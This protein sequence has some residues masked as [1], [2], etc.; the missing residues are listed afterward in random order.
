MKLYQYLLIAVCILLSGCIRKSMNQ[1][2][3]WKAV[4]K[5][6]DHRTSEGRKDGLYTGDFITA[7]ICMCDCTYVFADENQLDWNKR[8][9]IKYSWINP[10]A[11]TVMTANRWNDDEQVW[12]IA[13][14]NHGIKKGS[15]DYQQ[16]LNGA[17]FTKTQITVSKEG[18]YTLE[19]DI[20]QHEGLVVTRISNGFESAVDSVWFGEDLPQTFWLINPWWGGT[21]PAQTRTVLKS[22][23]DIRTK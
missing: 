20:H 6:G 22:Y 17:Q 21:Y 3:Y 4:I 11:K 7:D 5:K 1:N 16:I 23:Y 2:F 18:C 13:F 9:G 10:H 19:R 12:E 14:Y 15:S 8:E